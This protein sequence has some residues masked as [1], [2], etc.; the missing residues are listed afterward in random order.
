MNRTADPS[1]SR[2][3]WVP[4]LAL[5]GVAGVAVLATGLLLT[6]N[7]SEPADIAVVAAADHLVTG[8]ATSVEAHDSPSIARNPRDAKVLVVADKVDRPRFSAALTTSQDDGKTW[9]ALRFP[10]PIGEDRPY[11]PDLA[12]TRDGVLHLSFVTLSG[13]GNSPGAGWISSSSDAGRTWAAPRKVLGAHAFQVRLA[14]DPAGKA[15]FL[16]WLQADKES[17]SGLLSFTR[18]GLPVL[19]ARSTDGGHSFSTPTQVSAAGRL[20][21]GAAVPQVLPNGDLAV[22]YEDFKDDRRDFQNLEGG[23]YDGT[24]ALVLARS[25]PDL[26]R[27]TEAVVAGDI[28]PTERFLVYLPDFPSLAAGDN[29]LYA[30]WTDGRSGSRDVFVRRSGDGGRTWQDPVRVNSNKDGEQYLPAVSVA[31]G[32]RVDLVYL[33]RAAGGQLTG[34]RYAVSADRGRSWATI[35][36]G[37]QLFSAAVGPGSELGRPDQGTRLA[38]LSRPDGA[39]AVWTDARLGTEDTGKLD[40][41]FASVGIRRAHS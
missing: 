3:R 34:A 1:R 8:A 37:T 33:D 38:V 12:W 11:A 25:A 10:V 4:A 32:G 24:F 26:S 5:A 9:S 41:F 23:V 27:F 31:P 14:A 40:V 22:L 21:V 39:D 15:V 30:A 16:T 18:T 19:A 20:R 17:T 6:L 2:P 13:T 7:S 35:A 29:D 36:L 28:V